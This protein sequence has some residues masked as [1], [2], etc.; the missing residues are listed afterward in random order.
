VLDSP[1]GVGPIALLLGMRSG[2]SAELW[3]YRPG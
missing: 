1:V 2:G 3:E